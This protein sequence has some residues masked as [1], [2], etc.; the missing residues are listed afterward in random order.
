MFISSL[1]LPA[2]LPLTL[3]AVL[4]RA[5]PGYPYQTPTTSVSNT[6]SP[7]A[8]ATP[9]PFIVIAAHSTSPIHLQSVDAAQGGFYIG[10]GSDGYCP[11]ADPS[12]C[13]NGSYTAFLVGNGG[14]ALGM[15]APIPF[16]DFNETNK[17][18]PSRRPSSRRTKC[19]RLT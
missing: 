1:L 12:E 11:L 15:M 9:T 6:T 13:A 3:A 7:T 5:Q 18:L 4:G 10:E 16:L 19:V 14:C 2:F 8:A 17:I